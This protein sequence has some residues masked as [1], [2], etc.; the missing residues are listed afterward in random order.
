MLA[1]VAQGLSKKA[2]KRKKTK[3]IEQKPKKEEQERRKNP[4]GKQKRVQY[5]NMHQKRFRNKK[6][7]EGSLGGGKN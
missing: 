1:P 7:R 3:K 6:A 2:T 5:A 4:K